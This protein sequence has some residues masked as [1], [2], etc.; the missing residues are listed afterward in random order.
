MVKDAKKSIYG[1][2]NFGPTFG[3]G[4]DIVI[5]DKSNIN[6][7]SYS[8]LGTSYHYPPENRDA[9]SFL[10]DRYDGWLTT[11]IEVHQINK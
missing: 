10:A 1:S 7:G 11:E 3:S 4:H 2:P 5:K 8:N 6:T 9:R